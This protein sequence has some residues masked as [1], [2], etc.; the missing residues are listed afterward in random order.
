MVGQLVANLVERSYQLGS[1]TTIVAACFAA[2]LTGSIDTI[3]FR[4]HSI[5]TPQ[6]IRASLQA[7]GT[8]D[9]N[10]TGT[11]LGATNNGFGAVASPTAT[12]WYNVTLGESVAVTAGDPLAMVFDWP[13]TQGLLFLT[14]PTSGGR[15]VSLMCRGSPR[16]GKRSYHRS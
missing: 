1:T 3:G 2:P 13:G 10:P 14:G 6:T 12:T 5:T 4:V 8:S 7:C 11:I 16:R 15:T 9:G